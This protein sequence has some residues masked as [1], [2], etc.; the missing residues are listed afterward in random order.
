[1]KT[2]IAYGVRDNI[3]GCSALFA[4]AAAATEFLKALFRYHEQQ[5]K[6]YW[7]WYNTSIELVLTT[8]TMPIAEYSPVSLILTAQV[9]E[10]LHNEW[11]TD[12]TQ[13]KTRGW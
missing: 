7:S 9:E 1:M 8:F 5:R 6:K 2:R 3:D 11:L 4:S 10:F 12:A 13:R